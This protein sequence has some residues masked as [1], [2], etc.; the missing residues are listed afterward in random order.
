[1]VVHTDDIDFDPFRQLSN[2]PEVR[3]ISGFLQPGRDQ[4][5]RIS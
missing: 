2:L 5:G 4:I 3:S 1:M